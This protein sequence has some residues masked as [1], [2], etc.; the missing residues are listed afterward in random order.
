MKA[1]QKGFT[2]IE[3]MIVVAII[4]ILAAVALPA[5]NNYTNKARYSEMVMAVSPIKTALS[6]A[7]QDGSG[8]TAGAWNPQG[9]GADRLAVLGDDPNTPAV[10]TNFVLSEL[11]IPLPTANGKVVQ[12]AYDASGALV[13]AQWNVTGHGTN[14]LTITG[15]PQAVGGI[16]ATD[17]LIFNATVDAQ[18]NVSYNIDA[19]SGCKK[20]SGGAIC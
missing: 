5:Y 10:E 8:V 7:A 6:V 1:L 11:T 3:L 15:T 17:T 4:G 13:P 20:K 19:N 9:T 16:A 12:T 2:L 18:G 14:T